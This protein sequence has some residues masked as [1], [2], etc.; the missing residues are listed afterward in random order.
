MSTEPEA[1]AEA[2]G[3]TRV[4]KDQFYATIGPKNV[5]PYPKGRHHQITGYVTE[6]RYVDGQRC[7][8]ISDGGTTFL[9]SRYW[10]A[11]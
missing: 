9:P 5:H 8:G 3:M 7:V 2:Q 4:E 1:P 6:W 10:L 11:K